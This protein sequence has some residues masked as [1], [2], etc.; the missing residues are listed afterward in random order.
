MMPTVKTPVDMQSMGLL[1]QNKTDPGVIEPLM[2]S[3]HL[4]FHEKVENLLEFYWN[5]SKIIDLKGR[6]VNQ[7]PGLHPECFHWSHTKF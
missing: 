3:R 4:Y 5:S 6:E 1:P 2:T 7:N